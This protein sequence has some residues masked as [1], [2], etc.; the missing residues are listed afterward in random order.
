MSTGHVHAPVPLQ[1]AKVAQ[2]LHNSSQFQ[3]PAKTCS[4]GWPDLLHPPVPLQGGRVAQ[5]LR[6]PVQRHDH[7]E[8]SCPRSSEH[9]HV[10]V[11]RPGGRVVQPLH[12]PAQHKLRIGRTMQPPFDRGSY[13]PLGSPLQLQAPSLTSEFCLQENRHHKK[14]E[15]S[16]Q[17]VHLCYA[18]SPRPH[19]L[20]PTLRSS[21]K[22]HLR[23]KCVR[24]TVVQQRCLRPASVSVAESLLSA[25]LTTFLI[26]TFCAIF[27]CPKQ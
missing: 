2:P 7:P 25:Q 9:V 23:Q 20:M 21:V 11:P 22:Q 12:N 16:S 1:G 18:C 13:L 5:L 4:Q 10:L 27:L 6:C 8:T 19:R 24:R 17:R 26:K 15:R 14:T 3:N